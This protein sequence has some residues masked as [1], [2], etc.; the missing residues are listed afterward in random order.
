MTPAVTP[1]VTKV[2]VHPVCRLAYH[3]GDPSVWRPSS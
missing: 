3:P 1:S 2:P